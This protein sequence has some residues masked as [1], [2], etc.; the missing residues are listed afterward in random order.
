MKKSLRPFFLFLTLLVVLANGAIPANAATPLFSTIVTNGPATNRVN[1]VIF[2]EGYTSA[3]LGQF[4]VDATNAANFFL[5]AQPY[6]EY[7]NFFNVFAIATNSAHFG[8]THL[9]STTY[10]NGYTYFNSTYDGT[11]DY[12]ITI[13][14]N[15]SDS[16]N[17]HGQGKI[18][19]L[20]QLFLPATN[21]DLAALLINDPTPGGSDNYGT[22]AIAS[23]NDTGDEILLH[24]SGHTLGNLG[25]EYTTPYPGYPDT[26]P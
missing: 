6:A 24:E 21:N 18:I 15:P 13:P 4:L 20:L 11:S 9:I 1:L 8:S 5:G 23:V 7:S 19:S 16:T 2:S 3:Q 10:T 14:P 17:S 22:T 25:D 26:C 12:I